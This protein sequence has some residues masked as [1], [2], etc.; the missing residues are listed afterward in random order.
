MAAPLLIDVVSDAFAAPLDSVV[1]LVEPIHAAP[2]AA[3]ALES[4]WSSV[5]VDAEQDGTPPIPLVSFE[6]SP[7]PGAASTR[8][9]LRNDDLLA[10]SAGLA[11]DARDQ[12]VLLGAPAFARPL[13][14][15]L[16]IATPA[17]I[18]FVPVASTRDGGD[19]VRGADGTS[20]DAWWACGMLLRVLLDELE[21]V[22]AGL[23][24]AAGLAVRI[25]QGAEP[26]DVELAASLRWNAH[27]ARG[28]SADDLRV[29]SAV[30]SIGIVP[31]LARDGEALVAAA[32][33]WDHSG[34]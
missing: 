21:A 25:A 23:T 31:R 4:G 7:S 14:A 26:A 13:C 12:L 34:S 11:L 9:R 18:S 8:C 1:V 33:G 17:S 2:A 28:G 3:L 10:A 15:R 30:D 29:A 6:Q 32:W 24:D 22:D 20:S 5:Q 16:A 19:H 27:L